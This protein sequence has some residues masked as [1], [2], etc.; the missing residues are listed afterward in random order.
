[1]IALVV[2]V[3]FVLLDFRSTLDCLAFALLLG[4]EWEA[5]G[6]AP[7]RYL[8]TDQ[9]S[10]TQSFHSDSFMI[11]ALHPETQGL[12][13]GDSALRMKV[14]QVSGKYSE[15]Q[16]VGTPVS[17]YIKHHSGVQICCVRPACITVQISG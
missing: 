1:M 3:G 10:Q 17:H 16:I 13:F 8:A 12:P 5:P 4:D 2:D 11:T 7:A 9:Y 6:P 14:A 15:R